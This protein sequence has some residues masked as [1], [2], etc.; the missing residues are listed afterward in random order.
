MTSGEAV[1]YKSSAHAF[2]EIIKNEGAKSLFKG[3]GMSLLLLSSLFSLFPSPFL[4]SSP[5]PLSSSCSH[6]FSIPS[7]SVF[8]P[9]LIHY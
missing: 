8:D 6:C 2:A 9:F 1:K 5:F 4:L 3:A 7:L